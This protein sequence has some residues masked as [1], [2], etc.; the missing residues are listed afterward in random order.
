MVT[1]GFTLANPKT[2]PFPLVGKNHDDHALELLLAPPTVMVHVTGVGMSMR[3]VDEMADR[4]C[5]SR[6]YSYRCYYS[7]CREC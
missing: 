1:S 7:D 4:H 5:I 3:L 6:G 2:P